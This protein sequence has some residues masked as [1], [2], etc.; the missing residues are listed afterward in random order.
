[1]GVYRDIYVGPYLVVQP[2]T[3]IE[4][5]TARVCCNPK[6]KSNKD[7]HRGELQKFC[8]LCGSS[9]VDEQRT[10]PYGCSLLSAAIEEILPGVSG[11]DFF[12]PAYCG[13]E[14]NNTVSIPNRSTNDNIAEIEPDRI[15]KEL[16]LFENDYAGKL[17]SIR[18]FFG[19]ENVKVCWGVIGYEH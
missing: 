7:K 10:K 2:R 1:M 16:Y 8:P 5:Y 6:C 3:S 9:I 12:T 13:G 19:N 14:E 15:G 17:K 4:T 11:D 18:E